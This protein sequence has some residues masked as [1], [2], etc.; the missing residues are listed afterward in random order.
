MTKEDYLLL[1]DL[2][3]NT[4]QLFVEFEKLENEKKL[5]ENENLELRTS[6]ESL[7]QEKSDISRKNEKLKIAN[8]LLLN[9]DESGEVKKK[10]NR[11]VRE[12]DKCIA[13]LNK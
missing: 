7:K 6:I 5:L 10:I 13:L 8:R 4:R 9:K 3:D 2:K 12:I 1:T 11:L